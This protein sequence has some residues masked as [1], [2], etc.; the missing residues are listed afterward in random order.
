MLL[1]LLLSY[2]ARHLIDSALGAPTT[3]ALGNNGNADPMLACAAASVLIEPALPTQT[4]FANHRSTE[5]IVW[6][7]IGTMV[8]CSWAS[9]HPNM[10]GFR[11]SKISMHLRHL[12][13]AFWAIVAPEAM[14]FWAMRQWH[15]A[16]VLE[17]EFKSMY[18]PIFCYGENVDSCFC[19]SQEEGWTMTHGHFLQMGGFMLEVD[20]KKISVLNPTDLRTFIDKGRIDLATLKITKSKIDELSKTSVLARALAVIQILWFSLQC[21]A[22]HI[23]GLPITNL[24]LTT[25]ALGAINGAMYICWS[26]KPFQPLTTISIPVIKKEDDKDVFVEGVHEPGED[27]NDRESFRL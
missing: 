18:A 5:D 14:I 20:G 6:S 10:Q 17:K 9:V 12:A 13:Y 27:E 24:E 21:I 15:G 8:A 19:F 4:P 16:R 7:C 23:E 26:E 2:L 11:E 22:R 1:A 3:L 25:A